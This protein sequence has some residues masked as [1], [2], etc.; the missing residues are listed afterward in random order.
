MVGRYNGSMPCEAD[1]PPDD[2]EALK[3]LLAEQRARADAHEA[4]VVEHEEKLAE[5]QSQL[6]QKDVRIAALQEQLNLLTA[7][8]YGPSSEKADAGQMALFDE[9][10][11]A[12][13]AED[14]EE[15]EAATTPA[16]PRKKPG[17]RP[18]PD[19]IERVDVLHDLPEAD[20]RCP[21]DGTPLERMGE[22]VSEQLDVI[23]ARV[24]VLRHVRPR[25]GCP[26]CRE[27]VTTAKMPPQPI[28]K[29]IASPGLLAQ[30]CTGKYADALPL[31]RQEAILQRTGVDIPR[32]TLAGWVL[33]LGELVVPLTNLLRDT[34][35]GSDI[36]QMDE[37]TVSVLK[38]P[39]RP[40]TSTSYMW[41]QR[42]GPPDKPVVLFDYEPTRSQSVPTRL[43]EGFAGHLQCDGYGGYNAVGRSPGVR[44][45]GCW[46][47]ARR[48]FDEAAR[49]QG[50]KGSGKPT[51]RAGK[52]LSF[53]QKLYRVEKQ[54]AEATADQRRELRQSQAVPVLDELRA[55]LDETRPQVPP[56]SAVGKALHYLDSEWDKLVRYV[57]DGRLAIDN[58][59]AERAIRP[60]V[61]GRNNWL[62][63]DTPKGAHASA[64]LYS[65]ISTARAN[66]HEPYQYLH[67]V[68]KEL[69]AAESIE[70][71]EAL[72]PFN[73]DPESLN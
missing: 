63:S 21:H 72:L 48:K 37:T 24:R 61:V 19:D 4:I 2:V 7:K 47:H 16:R 1:H 18:L 13:E 8:R 30:V 11:A 25:Y 44:L 10:E 27:G 22:E 31:H 70:E 62:F 68:F 6:Q 5:Q 38:E 69:P 51:G 58:N 50:K 65:L 17:R 60:F 55:W 20:K 64:R 57:E 53:I 52:G 41:V 23:P 46:A 42:G 66:G 56:K 39:D 67:H 32:A 33:K 28:P 35:L 3:A 45:V 29:S 26:C 54:A 9:A 73:L 40:A 15:P 71:L 49:A 34:L 59:A 12:L 43:L 14:E 36:I